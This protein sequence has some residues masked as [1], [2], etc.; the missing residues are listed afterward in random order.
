[1]RRTATSVLALSLLV[2]AGHAAFAQSTSALINETLDRPFKLEGN[3]IRLVKVTFSGPD[4]PPPRQPVFADLTLFL[5]GV[6]RGGVSVKLA[7][8]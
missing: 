8:P 4:G 6:A 7:G 2:A 5:D 3:E 1:M